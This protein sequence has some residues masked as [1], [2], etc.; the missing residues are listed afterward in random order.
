LETGTSIPSF[1]ANSQIAFEVF[2]PSATEPNSDKISL[3]FLLIL[4]DLKLKVKN[5][6]KIIKIY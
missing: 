4:I 6:K 2:T 3:I 5:I 1:L